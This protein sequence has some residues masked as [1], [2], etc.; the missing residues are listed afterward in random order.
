MLLENILDLTYPAAHPMMTGPMLLAA[1]AF[2]QMAELFPGKQVLEEAERST[3]EGD[4][5][6][7]S[8]VGVAA[9]A[10]FCGRCSFSRWKTLCVRNCMMAVCVKGTGA[11]RKECAFDKFRQRRIVEEAEVTVVCT[12]SRVCL[13]RTVNSVHSQK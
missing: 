2:A 1:S 10:L 3:I 13:S 4:D 5:E 9:R 12:S 11:A 7:S 8:T 6:A